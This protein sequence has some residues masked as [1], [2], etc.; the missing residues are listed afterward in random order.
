MTNKIKA[1]SSKEEIEIPDYIKEEAKKDP[2]YLIW[3]LA[4][5]KR[6]AERN[7]EEH[8]GEEHQDNYLITVEFEVA[9]SQEN[10]GVLNAHDVEMWLRTGD[11]DL[12]EC[13]S[14]V[15][16]VRRPQDG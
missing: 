7:T 9:F 15:V 5:E 8:Q 16:G 4:K 6:I 13:L 1:S 10:D 2:D 14:K 12:S 3:W 11:L